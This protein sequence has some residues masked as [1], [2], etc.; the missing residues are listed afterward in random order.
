MAVLFYCVLALALVAVLQFVFGCGLKRDLEALRYLR[1]QE[2]EDRQEERKELL[3]EI[4]NLS[5]EVALLRPSPNSAGAA[6][7]SLNLSRRNQVVRMHMRGDSQ[8]R[9]ASALRIGKGEVDL[10][11]KLHR[12]AARRSPLSP[13][14]VAPPP[15]DELTAGL[16]VDLGAELDA[17]FPLSR[18]A[19][20][21]GASPLNPEPSEWLAKHRQT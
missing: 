3:T 15:E 13:D 16:A 10:M 18:R 12:F 8:E 19:A 4:A 20:S 17:S 11:L 6:G 14:P 2:A 9:I 21:P 5:Q 1:T 7:Y